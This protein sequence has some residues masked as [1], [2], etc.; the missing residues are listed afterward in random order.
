MASA[1]LETRRIWHP[2]FLGTAELAVQ[3]ETDLCAETRMGL[4]DGEMEGKKILSGSKPEC[5]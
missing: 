1:I 2:L 5:V 4:F 3:V